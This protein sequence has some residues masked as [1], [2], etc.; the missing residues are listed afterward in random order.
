MKV[1]KMNEYMHITLF[2][3][4]T[5]QR[6]LLFTFVQPI[7]YYVNYILSINGFDGYASQLMYPLIMIYSLYVI[8]CE[9]I[10]QGK[11][12]IAAVSIAITMMAYSYVLNGNA[13]LKIGNARDY[14]LSETNTM[15]SVVLPVILLCI[16]GVDVKKYLDT[17]RITS[18]III[19]MQGAVF[20]LST[21]LNKRPISED[22][23]SYAY[24][25][26]YSLFICCYHRKES[27]FQSVLF[28]VGLFLQIIAGCRGAM[29]TAIVFCLA[30]EI[31]S[32][33][34]LTA[35]NLLRNILLFVIFGLLVFYMDEAVEILN[36]NL[37]KI[38]F[39]SRTLEKLQGENGGFFSGERGK[40]YTIVIRNANML[41]YGIFGDRKM[42][43]TYSHNWILEMLMH[44][45]YGFASIIVIVIIG[46]V[47]VAYF[48]IRKVRNN[49]V[50]TF[51][52]A[53][54]VALIAGKFMFSSSYLTDPAFALSLYFV[55]N[56]TK[57]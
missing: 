40:L 25:G 11:K 46:S 2:S 5:E 20:V 37:I 49:T 47:M 30:Y 3:E 54:A 10:L 38:G 27:I 34:E 35:T 21:A 42:L 8:L 1:L 44:F 45:G 48:R 36:D 26:I 16:H 32:K 23:M 12:A 51:Q 57:T 24:S 14:I 7:V 50:E 55:Y 56:A 28:W 39:R 4:K 43:G 33:K 13:V 6:L 29:I 52:F 22:Y 9:M 19:I 53:A 18:N 41:G 17:S 31:S 15:F